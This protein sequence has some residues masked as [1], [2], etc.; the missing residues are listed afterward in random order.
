LQQQGLS[1]ARLYGETEA[2][3]LHRLS[4][5]FDEPAQYG[6]PADPKSPVTA[7]A[8]Q[9]IV[10]PLGEVVF[11]MTLLGAL[12]AFLLGRRNIHMEGVE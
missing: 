10:Q 2:A 11:G 6:L 5:M 8:W 9:K 3:G 4:I 12:A 7:R 1:T